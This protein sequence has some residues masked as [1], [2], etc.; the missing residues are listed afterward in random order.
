MDFFQDM[1][2]GTSVE[3]VLTPSGDMA[4]L[5]GEILQV[6]RKTDGTDVRIPGEVHVPVQSDHGNVIVQ[7]ARIKV[8]VDEDVRGVEFNVSVKLRIV[9]H[10]PFTQSNSQVLGLVVLDTVGRGED[11]RSID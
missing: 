5:S 6:I 10:V 7:V 9:V 2:V 11:V 1:L 4:A 8:L 3:G